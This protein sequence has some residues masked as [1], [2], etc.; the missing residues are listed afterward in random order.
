MAAEPSCGKLGDEIA[1][2]LLLPHEL[3]EVLAQLIL[4]HLCPAVHSACQNNLK[5]DK[6]KRFAQS[7]PALNSSSPIPI[8]LKILP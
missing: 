6:V 4:K 5:R 1:A 7:F 2:E 3:E 8:G